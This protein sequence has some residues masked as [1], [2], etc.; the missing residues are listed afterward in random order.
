MTQK[1]QQ[2]EIENFQIILYLVL[3]TPSFQVI[4]K[5]NFLFINR[6]GE[7]FCLLLLKKYFIQI[8]L[9]SNEKKVTSNGLKVT[10]SEQKITSIKI[11]VTSSEKKVTSNEQKVTSNKQKVTSNEQILTNNELKATTNEQI[12]MSNKQKLISNEQRAKGF[13][14]ML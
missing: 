14:S 10:S 4:H 6:Y 13:T 8:F 3:K 7:L 11:K 2:P 9:P 5:L 1:L 12:L